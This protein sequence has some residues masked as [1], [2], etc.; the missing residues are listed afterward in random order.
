[1]SVLL[2]DMR[3]AVGHGLTI[4]PIRTMLNHAT[5]ELFFDDLEVPADN[6]I[7]EEGKGFRY[8]LDGMNAERILI[9]AECIGDARFF[10][11]QA[12]AYAKDAQVFGRPIGQNQGVQFPIARA[13]VQSRGRSA[14]G[15]TRPPSCSRPASPAAP[16]PTWPSCRLGGVV[17]RRRHVPADARRLRLRRGVRHR[18][19]VPR[20]AALSGRADLDEPDPVARGR[21]TCWDCRGPS[22]GR[23]SRRGVW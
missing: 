5:T 2:V 4:R 11:D 21:R 16:R 22:D 1:M 9:A 20:D 12:S 15:A 19:Q 18:A 23:R 14:D 17:V 3:E 13:Y 6:L 10:I 7:G 8:I